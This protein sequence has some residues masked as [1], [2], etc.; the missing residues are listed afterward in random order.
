MSTAIFYGNRGPD[1]KNLQELL[2]NFHPSFHLNLDDEF[3]PRTEAAVRVFQ[4]S[5]GI[6]IDG[7]AGAITLAALKK[8]VPTSHTVEVSI[9]MNLKDAPWMAVAMREIG[10][11]EIRGPQHNPR[12]IEYHAATAL[13]A[14]TDET[15]WCSSFVNW[16]LQQVS[17]TGTNSAAAVSW[18]NWG[19]ASIPKEGA[20]TVVHQINASNSGYHVAFFL[21]DC[22]SHHSL[23]GGNQSNRVKAS[24]YPK[25]SWRIVAQRWPT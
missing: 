21:K 24:L 10:Q 5:I 2:N 11:K 12:I 4:A 20:I 19:Q 25:T 23:L 8:G 9:Q 1:V 3:G 6:G 15:P 22:G 13:K 17:I 16:C 18:I 7:V 14:S